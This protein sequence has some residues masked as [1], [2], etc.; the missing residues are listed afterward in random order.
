MMAGLEKNNALA[1][2]VMGKIADGF[3]TG[4]QRLREANE[5][6]FY[7]DREARCPQPRLGQFPKLMGAG[8][9]RHPSALEKSRRNSK[10]SHRR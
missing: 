10:K 8:S 9:L 5:V 2:L 3:A 7:L 1:R 4:V 6:A